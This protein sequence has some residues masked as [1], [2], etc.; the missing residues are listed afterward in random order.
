MTVG[1]LHNHWSCKGQCSDRPLTLADREVITGRS[2][3]RCYDEDTS[4]WFCGD[5][6]A[7]LPASVEALSHVCGDPEP[8]PAAPAVEHNTRTFCPMPETGYFDKRGRPMHDKSAAALCTCGWVVWGDNRVDARR[9]AR[10]HR[11]T[12]E[13]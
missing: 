5:C 10:A 7:D 3:L 11:E 6:L 8:V 2:D 4:T 12:Q 13:G 9:L 1:Q